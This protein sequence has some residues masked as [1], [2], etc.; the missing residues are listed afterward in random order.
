MKTSPADT[1]IAEIRAVRDAHASRFGYDV[2]AIFRDLQAR[3]A[4]SGRKYE[5]RPPKALEPLE[6]AMREERGRLRGRMGR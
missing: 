3:Q 1:I 2:Q 5:R 6:P 4:A